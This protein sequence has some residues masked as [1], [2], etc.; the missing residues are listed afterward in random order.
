MRKIRRIDIRGIVTSEFV[1]LAFHP[2]D[3]GIHW[4]HVDGYQAATA[5]TRAPADTRASKCEGA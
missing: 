5:P 1:F 2:V 3:I 4:H